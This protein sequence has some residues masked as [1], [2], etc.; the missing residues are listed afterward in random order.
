[1]L[2]TYKSVE[3]FKRPLGTHP[4]KVGFTFVHELVYKFLKKQTNKRTRLPPITPRG[5]TGTEMSDVYCIVTKDLKIKCN[6]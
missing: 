2:K 3:T 1:M 4:S 5:E 6:F